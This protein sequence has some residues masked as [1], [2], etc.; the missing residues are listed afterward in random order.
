MHACVQRHHTGSGSA[1][2]PPR[3][4]VMHCRERTSTRE[5]VETKMWNK[6]LI[7]VFFVQKVFL[8]LCKFTV[9]PLMLHGI[10]YRSPCYISGHGNISVVLLSMGGSESSQIQSKTS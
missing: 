2:A 9:E 1:L 10:F 4:C 5:R 8:W 7:F 3:T 6:I